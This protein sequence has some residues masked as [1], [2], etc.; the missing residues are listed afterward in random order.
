LARIKDTRS[1]RRI[2]LYLDVGEINELAGNYPNDISVSAII[3]DLVR[4]DNLEKRIEKQIAVDQ[5]KD[6]S[7]IGGALSGGS[8]K[9]ITVTPVMLSELLT[10]TGK[11]R[12]L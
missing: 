9:K 6:S 4:K 3:R 10:K 7:A 5:I 8:T 12:R 2:D 1:N 11:L